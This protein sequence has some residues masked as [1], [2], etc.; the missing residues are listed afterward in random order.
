MP[1]G[2]RIW[3]VQTGEE[4]PVDPGPPRLLRTALLARELVRRGHD[5]TFW[6]ASF[7]HQQ[8]LQRFETSKFVALPD[9]YRAC[10]LHGRA[11]GNHVSLA[12]IRSH[13]E[14]AR[15][16]SRLAPGEPKPDVILCGLPTLEL[17]EAVARFA[18]SRNVPFAIDCR[19]MWPDVIAE[20]LPAPIRLAAW[21]V[22][23]YWRS[24]RHK[25]LSQATAVTGVTESFVDWGLA[26]AGRPR[27]P[28]DRAFHLAIPAEL[29]PEKDM[30]AASAF[31]DSKLGPAD[32]D[33]VTCCFAGTLSR[34]LDIPAFVQGAMQL[35]GAL[36]KKIRI[37]ICGK[38]DLEAEVKARIGAAP[39]ILFAGWR[40]AAELRSLMLRS[41]FGILPYPCTKDFMSHFVNKVGEYMSAGLP[42][43]TG[44]KGLTGD[45]LASR[46]LGLPYA[47][48]EPASVAN[49]LGNAIR[50]VAILR[51]KKDAAVATYRELFDPNR[52]YPGFADWL[53]ALASAG[54]L[55]DQPAMR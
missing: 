46:D 50:D 6:N 41:D 44:L 17:S 23:A 40:S 8:K 52:I 55:R 45:L 54:T 20:L 2:L 19:D 27:R 16:F 13:Q 12:R 11:Y 32:P 25:A 35:D 4:L 53:Q 42:V 26:A 21:P 37:V 22:L 36:Q 48:G 31:W 38:G 10:F 43:M 7:N 34:R 3:L 33:M 14:N 39:H 5:V 30:A 1:S 9:G 49:A 28:L 47:V 29:P 24:L 15:E 51:G 18:A